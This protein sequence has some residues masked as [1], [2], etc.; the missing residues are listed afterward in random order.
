MDYE[1]IWTE[2]ATADFG[3]IVDYLTEHTTD[4]SIS[5]F[6]SAFYRKLDLLAQMPYMGVKSTKREGVRRL[7]ITKRY[8]LI[9]VLIVDQIYLLR[10]YDNRSD[11]EAMTF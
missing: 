6:V 11:P 7:L 1:V 3:A 4:K 9:Y 10:V 8:S 5:K 2:E